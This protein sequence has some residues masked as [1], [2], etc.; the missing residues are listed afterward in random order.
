MS[1][2]ADGRAILSGRPAVCPCVVTRGPGGSKPD[3]LIEADGK[4]ICAEV[5]VCGR[6]T[7]VV[8]L[9][10]VVRCACPSSPNMAIRLH[11]ARLD[12]F[13]LAK[14]ADFSRQQCVNMRALAVPEATTLLQLFS[15]SRGAHLAERI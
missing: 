9:S 5:H 12:Y 14:K 11:P 1:L 13:S 7:Q 10:P 2:P 15:V 8:R 3:A 6:F 4:V